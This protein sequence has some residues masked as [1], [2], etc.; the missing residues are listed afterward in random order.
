M[1]VEV[2][3]RLASLLAVVDHGSETAG[4]E[5]VADVC[6]HEHDVSQ[7]LLQQSWNELAEA[8]LSRFHQLSLPFSILLR[9]YLYSLG[10]P[11]LLLR[12]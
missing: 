9:T 2:V 6:R 4:A 10:I 7:Q 11:K 3:D 1:N 5:L 12:L 8:R